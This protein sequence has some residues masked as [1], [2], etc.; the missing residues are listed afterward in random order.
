MV[1]I[2]KR[3]ELLEALVIAV[4]LIDRNNLELWSELDFVEY[5]DIP[6]VKELVE[7]IHIEKYSQIVEYIKDMT[8][9]GYYT[10][11]FLF[12]DDNFNFNQK[13][14]FNP[15][16]KK[17]VLDFAK[18]VKKIYD[19]ENIESIFKK[20]TGY[21]NTIENDFAK[22][23]KIDYKEKLNIMY[24][25]AND[26]KFLTNISLLINGAFSASNE[27]CVSYIKGIK[28][29][30][31]TS[32][33]EFNEY[34]IVC[35]FHEHS[36][37]FVNNI[38]DKYFEK[39]NNIDFL[40]NESLISGLPLTYQNEKTLLY[41][42]FV[43]ANSLLLCNNLISKQEYNDVIEWYK[44]LGFIRIEEI[45]SIVQNGLDQNFKFEEIFTT[46]I[47]NYFNNLKN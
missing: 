9:C 27:S 33:I 44:E 17:N 37:Y 30:N 42:Y 45:I 14:Q 29:D 40:Y 32:Q 41:E 39:I 28:I 36:H 13:V 31:K 22:K 21:L 4:K 24:D 5:Y 15:F 19:N 35:M 38:V 16:E 11:L 1:I 12:F 23:L 7:R 2:D 26:I 18:L 47:L 25:N 3:I 20:Y 43:R 8:D 10:N 46:Y 6:Y 34:T